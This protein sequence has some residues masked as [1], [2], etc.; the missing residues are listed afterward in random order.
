MC[1]ICSGLEK[2]TLTPWEAARNLTE[3]GNS[4]NKEHFEEVAKEINEL[5]FLERENICIFCKNPACECSDE[6]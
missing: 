4:L 6:E 5:L 1:I 3:M 2:N